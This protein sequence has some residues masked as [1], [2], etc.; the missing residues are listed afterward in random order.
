MTKSGKRW[1]VKDHDG[2]PIYLTE[3]R[4][5]HIVDG[6]NHPE[7]QEYEEHLKIT[8]QKGQRQQE[9]L[10]PQKYRYA[11]F[12]DNLLGEFNYLVAIVLFGSKVDDQNNVE[13]NNFVT[14]AFLKYIHMKSG[15]K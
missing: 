3:E 11:R 12:F 4:W 14:T 10:N 13:P 9:P 8:L 1:T 2:H 5:R 15:K 6:D 7:M